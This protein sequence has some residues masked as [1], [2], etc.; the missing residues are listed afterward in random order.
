MC[1]AM[2]RWCEKYE[3]IS[4][5]NIAKLVFE[6]SIKTKQVNMDFKSV[7]IAELVDHTENL[8][9]NEKI[10]VRTEE[11]YSGAKI[12]KEFLEDFDKCMSCCDHECGGQGGSELLMFC[13]HMNKYTI[14]CQMTY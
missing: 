1:S 14:N 4:S 5:F 8:A 6:S 13:L 12:D 11:L 7:S 2:D 9:S 10:N 3:N